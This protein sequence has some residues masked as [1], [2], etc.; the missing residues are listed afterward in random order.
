MATEAQLTE[1][2]DK[3]GSTEQSL[4]GS[5]APMGDAGGGPG[6]SATPGAMRPAS[7]SARPNIQQYLKANMGAGSVLG[8]Q[9]QQKYGQEQ[10][11]FNKELN[12]QKGQFDNTTNPLQQKLGDEGNQLI[13]TAFKDP[14]KLLNQQGK[15][16]EANTQAQEFTKMRTG[17]YNQDLANLGQQFG[18]QKAALGAQLGNLGQQADMAKSEGGRFQLLRQNF[19]SPTYSRGQQRLDQLFLQAQPGVARNLAQTMSQQHAGAGQAFSAADAD[20]QAKLQAL[21]G[22][23]GE[24]S[25]QIGNILKGGLAEGLDAD[26]SGRGF[27]DIQASSDA[28]Y[29]SAQ[30][31]AASAAGIQDRLQG[32]KLTDADRAALGFTAGNPVY[33]LKLNSYL[34]GVDANP[35]FAS[36]ANADEFARYRALQQL[37]GDT[38]G[39]IFGGAEA[40][41]GWKPFNFNSDQYTKDLEA[42]RK[43]YEETEPVRQAQGFANQLASGQWGGYD[44]WAQQLAGQLKNVKTGNDLQKVLSGNTYANVIGNKNTYL[45]DYLNQ[46]ISM[47]NRKL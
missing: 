26:I 2:E 45:N 5:S 17:A 37:A 33:D 25:Q 40:V 12:K 16:D 27:D 30:E 15:L 31:R 43:Y 42:R 23:A 36:A 1:E 10:G 7:P 28:L 19:G 38:S 13:Q 18:Q 47:R 21:Q 9:I 11:N 8:N 44:A 6:M 39:D 35:T 22:L 41:G 20:A 14:S 32:L 3:N 34:S 29:K 24:R 46:L 4:P